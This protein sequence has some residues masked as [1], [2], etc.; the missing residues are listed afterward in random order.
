MVVRQI[1][2]GALY[3]VAKQSAHVEK[4]LA[5]KRN[6]Y[7]RVHSV[8]LD[9]NDKILVQTALGIAIKETVLTVY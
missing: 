3:P 9:F 4:L 2:A 7:V 1:T 5:K 8:F 6:A